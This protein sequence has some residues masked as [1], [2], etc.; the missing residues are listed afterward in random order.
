MKNK[1]LIKNIVKQRQEIDRLSR[2]K[3]KGLEYVE[4]LEKRKEEADIK[5]KFA[6]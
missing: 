1:N 4:A 6:P 3:K 5:D 2:M